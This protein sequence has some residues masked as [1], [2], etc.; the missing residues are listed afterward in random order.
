MNS[1]VSPNIEQNSLNPLIYK[2]S[3]TLNHRSHIGRSVPLARLFKTK[4]FFSIRTGTSR[5]KDA[6]H[7]ISFIILVHISYVIS[8]HD[9]EL[10]KIIYLVFVWNNGTEYPAAKK[11]SDW[12]LESSRLQSLTP[13]I[14]TLFFAI[15]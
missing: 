14:N 9:I 15:I 2:S 5:V 3:L 10:I 7:L 12:C 6:T 11:F 8:Q 1:K 13:S 4:D